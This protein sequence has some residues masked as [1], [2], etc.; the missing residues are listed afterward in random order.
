MAFPH[1]IYG[2]FG[3]EKKVT[4]GSKHRLG[5]R[6]ELLDGRVFY[7]AFSNGVIG[8]GKLVMQLNHPHAS[9]IKDRQVLAARA[10]GATTIRFKCT[11]SAIS[12]NQYQ[13]GLVFVNDVDGE[14]HV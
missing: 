7:Y 2:K 8:A 4:S 11:G 14:G 1:T 13:D 12:L 5:T 9:H 6:M 10:I 3:W